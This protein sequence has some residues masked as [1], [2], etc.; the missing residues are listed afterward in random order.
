MEA[1]LQ[2]GHTLEHSALDCAEKQIS[3]DA[4]FLFPL[5]ELLQLGLV[6]DGS[7]PDAVLDGLSGR[8]GTLWTLSSLPLRMTTPVA[9]DSAVRSMGELMDLRWGKA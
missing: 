5:P 9:W 2:S 4:V 3:I 8:R 6:L 7:G 1:G